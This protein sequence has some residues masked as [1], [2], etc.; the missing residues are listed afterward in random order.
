MTVLGIRIENEK[1]LIC[2][3]ECTA[4]FIEERGDGYCVRLTT[5]HPSVSYFIIGAKKHRNGRYY[6]LK[7]KEAEEIVETLVEEFVSLKDLGDYQICKQE[8]VQTVY[9]RNDISEFDDE[10]IPIYTKNIDD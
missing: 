7:L 3:I 9:V 6:M 4:C 1:K 2:I 8:S 10:E 5:A